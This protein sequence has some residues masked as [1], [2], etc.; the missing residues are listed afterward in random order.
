[1]GRAASLWI[2]ALVAGP[3]PVAWAQDAA[4]PPRTG[5]VTTPD[6]RPMAGARVQ[7]VRYDAAHPP[8]DPWGHPLIEFDPTDPLPRSGGTVVATVVADDEG[9]FTLPARSGSSEA[10]RVED[11]RGVAVRADARDGTPF[12]LRTQPARRIAIEVLG[13]D[14]HAVP[15]TARLTSRTTEGPAAWWYGEVAAGPGAPGVAW[16]P[17]EAPLEGFIT[18]KGR[19][20]LGVT[21]PTPDDEGRIVLRPFSGPA[22]LR[23]TVRDAEGRPVAGASARVTVS[24]WDG[25]DGA[26]WPFPPPYAGN[27]QSRV[28]LRGATSAADGTVDLTGLP[29]SVVTECTITADGQ[30]TRRWFGAAPL[31]AET[32]LAA[33]IAFEPA[34]AIRGHVRD[35]AGHP[36]H[37]V[38]VFAHAADR[39]TRVS[40]GT[41]TA[42][43][44]S[45]MLF[46]AAPGTYRLGVRSR[47]SFAVLDAPGLPTRLRD[48]GASHPGSDDL[49][50][51]LR[52]PAPTAEAIEIR[53]EAAARLRLRVTSPDGAPIPGATADV[54][55]DLFTDGET[56]VLALL[57]PH[58][59]PQ[60]L[61]PG[62]LDFDGLPAASTVALNVSAPGYAGVYG[63]RLIVPPSTALM[64]LHVVLRP[65]RRLRGRVVSAEGAPVADVGVV[66]GGKTVVET[67]AEGRFE[68]GDLPPQTRRL[69]LFGFPPTATATHLDVGDATRDAD[70]RTLRLPPD[71][72]T[73]VVRV[74]HKDQP[75]PGV[76]LDLSVDDGSHPR[77]RIADAEGLARF[78]GLPRRAFVVQSP[79]RMPGVKVSADASSI[80]LPL[81]NPPTPRVG[82]SAEDA[83][84]PGWIF[85]EVRLPDATPVSS[86]SV[87]LRWPGA[88]ELRNHYTT[89]L[90][91]HFGLPRPRPKTGLD[92]PDAPSPIGTGTLSID[93]VKDARGR[94]ANVRNHTQSLT[95]ADLERPL[96]VTLQAGRSITGRVVDED[97][98]PIVGAI[99]T[100]H[101]KDA[102]FADRPT[103][104]GP[105]DGDGRFE[106]VGLPDEGTISL[107]ARGARDE[108]APRA[109]VPVVP[110]V[111][112]TIVLRARRALVGTLVDDAGR[113]W[114]DV[115]VRLE[116]V[117]GTATPVLP[118]TNRA[119]LR[120]SETGAFR[121]ADVTPGVPFV[122]TVPESRSDGV[123][124][125]PV[126]VTLPALPDQPLHLIAPRRHTIVGRVTTEQ[127]AP[128]A[129][130]NVEVSRWFLDDPTPV[131]TTRVRTDAE[132]RFRIPN[133][134]AGPTALRVTPGR[135]PGGASTPPTQTLRVDVPGDAVTVRF[136]DPVPD[137]LVLDLA[138]ATATPTNSR[139][140][141]VGSDGSVAVLPLR[142]E[143]QTKGK[144]LRLSAEIGTRFGTAWIVFGDGRVACLEGLRASA[145]PVSVAPSPSHRT[146]ALLEGVPEPVARALHLELRRGPVTLP[147]TRDT[148][149]YASGP[150]APGRYT[151]H[152]S[153][154]ASA[155]RGRIDAP[156]SID[157]E[158][159]PEFKITYQ[160][161]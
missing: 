96:V 79:G 9:R 115:E 44:G 119:T 64:D 8:L 55:L 14:D 73:L 137:L 145:T 103:T 75:V 78:A 62:T 28:L 120:T 33:E 131:A 93:Q 108:W 97:A 80:D 152:V 141:A 35:A 76:P 113:P 31:R 110:G 72:R 143:R 109:P 140:F 30:P 127:G 47:G 74:V 27:P 46:P 156:E 4:P 94:P 155:L 99:V 32:T 91:G 25:P 11:A 125:F 98:A 159:T 68:A 150:L 1:M 105:T 100:A 157:V 132:G 41:A 37:D 42:A 133:L 13:P 66:I 95:A 10:L 135:F 5:R 104:L 70:E 111:A 69:S 52:V 26:A 87:R 39:P 67:D 122:V 84:H 116:A 151:V 53:L 19:L 36:A 54:R 128:V 117:H 48:R 89:P 43:D 124:P 106:I 12:E 38:E 16:I 107:T 56:R 49:P 138:D 139:F 161:E 50:G 126:S 134:R 45:F 22:R 20:A 17:A 148:G 82:P 40:I 2:L 129:D 142:A 77:V 136:P 123:G 61:D 21:L 3:T 146:R 7:V 58:Y 144:P 24:A 65:L 18:V 160:G 153:I 86:A 112:P 71:V 130:A 121:F 158:T 90:G 92:V 51:I 34:H 85:G 6:G 101:V 149:S 29:V 63:Q 81:T 154:G 83:V 57:P 59:L 102:S 114:T 23:L 118:A 15:A 147:L 60:P 88:H